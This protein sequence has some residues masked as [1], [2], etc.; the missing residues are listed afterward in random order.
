MTVKEKVKNMLT[1]GFILWLVG[2]SAGFILF[3]VV[4]KN[5]IGWVITPFATLLTIWVLFKKVKR[6]QLT[7]YFGTGVMWTIIAVVMDFIFIV[8]LLNTGTSYYKPDVIFYYLLTF[9]LPILVGY[10]KF[11]HKAPQ[12]ELF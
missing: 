2:Y 6:P 12:A 10:W 9:T 11:R 8:K 1:W 4:P 5:M 7:C 3:F